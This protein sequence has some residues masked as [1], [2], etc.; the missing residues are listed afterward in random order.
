MSN[1][2]LFNSLKDQDNELDEIINKEYN[3]QLESL[4]LIASE[5]FT[6]KSVLEANGTILTNKYS[7]GYPNKRY[8]GGNEYIDELELLTQKRALE[9]FSLDSDIWHVNV[10]SYSGSPANFS[11]YTALLTPGDTIMG[12]DL[13]SGGHLT[14]GFQTITKT[15][16]IKKM[17]NSSIYFNS[18]SYNIDPKTFL[19]DYDK[20]KESV[21]E[22]R[23][24]LIIVGASSYSRDFDYKLFSEI[25]KLVDAY[26]MCDMAHTSGLIACKLLNNPFEY[27]DV[28]TTTTHK[29]LRGP[30]AALIFCKNE[31]SERI[32]CSV[33]PKNQGGPHNNTISAVATAL[34]QVSTLKFKEYSK[35]VITNARYLSNKLMVFGFDIVTGGTDNHLLVVNLKTKKV[36]GA[37]FEKIAELCN[38]SVSKNTIY[39]DKSPM[40]P[41]GIRLGTPAMTT[42]GFKEKDVDFIANC[43]NEITELIIKIQLEN[44]LSIK[45]ADFMD[46]L[47]FYQKD[48]LQLKNEIKNYCIKFP[49]PN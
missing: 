41:S 28:I 31:L 45:L 21:L 27:C 30:R 29:T 18:K 42:R 11:V 19:I 23:P 44:P 9:A 14:H 15:G 22:H 49:L 16:E 6:S 36:S 40:N 24:K 17:S 35:Q 10:Q 48:I 32:D 39:G 26:L 13:Y 46:K 20:L 12:L 47:Q 25:S 38:M 2:I 33:F 5:N 8:Y 3:R 7:E 34:K 4:E 1:Q 37:K 43:I